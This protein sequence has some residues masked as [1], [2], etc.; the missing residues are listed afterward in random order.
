MLLGPGNPLG[1]P[2]L[3]VETGRH[4]NKG[5]LIY[6]S[7]TG[8]PVVGLF[9]AW[10]NPF[11][12]ILDDDYDEVIRFTYGG[13]PE[14]VKGKRVLVASKGADGVEGTEDDLKSW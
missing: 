8:S 1:V 4:R 10:G 3:T 14:V 12:V 6:E 7:G 2:F 11:R 9:D 5:G 13:K